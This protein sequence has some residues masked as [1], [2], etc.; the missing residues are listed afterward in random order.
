MFRTRYRLLSIRDVPGYRWLQSKYHRFEQLASLTLQ[1]FVDNLIKMSS[2]D[3]KVYD[4]GTV[5]NLI[6]ERV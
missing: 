4:K 3:G 6:I 2:K 1:M 5:I